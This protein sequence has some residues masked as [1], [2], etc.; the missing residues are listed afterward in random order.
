MFVRAV[1]QFLKEF[2]LPILVVVL[3]VGVALWHNA[4]LDKAYDKGYDKAKVECAEAQRK[5][6]EEAQGKI[7][8]IDKD[9]TKEA[10]D[11]KKEIATLRD[12]IRSGERRLSVRVA[13]PREGSICPGVGD[14][15]TRAELNPEDAENLV[16]I[17]GEGDAAIIQLGAAQ[18]IIRALNKAEE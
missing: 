12:S 10:E 4:E 2:W 17:A 5:A 7:K 6:N 8:Q 3:G 14:G 9:R 13:A 1:I 18:D 16:A 11:A 15:E